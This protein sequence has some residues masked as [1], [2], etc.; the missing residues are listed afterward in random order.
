MNCAVWVMSMGDL[1][2]GA[3]L[4]AVA[5]ELRQRGLEVREYNH[6]DELVEI[7]VTNSAD[8]GRG[9]VT[10]GYDG[11]IEWEYLGDIETRPGADAIRDLVVRLLKADPPVSGKQTGNDEAG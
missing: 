3:L 4:R 9:R 7:V 6:G 8:V 1:R 5:R 10:V 11:G 2:P